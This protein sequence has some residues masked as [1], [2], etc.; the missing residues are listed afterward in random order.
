[1]GFGLARDRSLGHHRLMSQPEESGPAN[2]IVGCAAVNDHVNNPPPPNF[3]TTTPIELF[4]VLSPPGTLLKNES[5]SEEKEWRIVLPL[6]GL[7]KVHPLEF[8]PTCDA[9]VPYVAYPLRRTGEEG[10]APCADVILGPGSHPL[11]E[12]GTTLFLRAQQIMVLAR[13]SQIPYRPR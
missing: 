4:R 1:M 10:P 12:V 3:G 9:T 2:V 8:R 13:R 6:R 5:F 11:A 7:P